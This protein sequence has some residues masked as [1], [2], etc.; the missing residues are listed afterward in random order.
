M[1]FLEAALAMLE[2]EEYSEVEKFHYG[3]AEQVTAQ[4]LRHTPPNEEPTVLP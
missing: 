4:G 3:H 2:G 1:W